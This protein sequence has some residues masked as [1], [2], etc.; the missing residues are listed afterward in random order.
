MP[1]VPV[2]DI[3]NSG[4][5]HTEGLKCQGIAHYAVLFLWPGQKKMVVVTCDTQD[6]TAKRNPPFLPVPFEVLH[7]VPGVEG[8][9]HADVVDDEVVE[10]DAGDEDEP[11]RDDRGE[12]VANL[13]GAEALD[14]E[15]QEENRHGD[16]DHLRCSKLKI[17]IYAVGHALTMPAALALRLYST[18]SESGLAPSP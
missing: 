17:V 12:G 5:M 9:Q 7:D 8:P 1:S 13:V 3:E 11:H 15:E 4:R 16:P 2:A 10:P 14:G 18:Y 6:D